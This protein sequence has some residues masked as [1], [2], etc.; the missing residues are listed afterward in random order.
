MEVVCLNI[1][2]SFQVFNSDLIFNML[3]CLP[4]FGY[5]VILGWRKKIS[6]ITTFL[7]LGLSLHGME[8]FRDTFGEHTFCLSSQPK[9]W[10]WFFGVQA[11]GGRGSKNDIT[12]TCVW[13]KDIEMLHC[14]L[15]LQLFYF[16]HF[17]KFL[18]I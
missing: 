4:S 18:Q 8:V 3:L 16:W 1:H 5:Q 17:N 14:I 6:L 11:S 13:L 2:A 15:L 12:P 7:L 9:M 10:E